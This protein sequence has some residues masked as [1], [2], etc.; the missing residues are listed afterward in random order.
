MGQ[1]P[2]LTP[3]VALQLAI[4]LK[5]SG[6]GRDQA[7]ESVLATDARVAYAYAM[8]VLS[9]V[10]REGEPAILTDPETAFWYAKRFKGRW[11]EAEP[12]IASSPATAYEYAKQVL[13]H[14]WPEAELVIMS[15][16]SSAAGY[17]IHVLNGPWPDAEPI[18][19]QS[20]EWT[21]WYRWL[22]TKDPVGRARFDEV[23]QWASRS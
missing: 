7:L 22:L 4:A 2:K 10:F 6:G 17:A 18:I 14:R 13:G 9:H 15:T 8:S 21:H 12:V 1:R 3:E 20:D 23:R 16:P 11:Q 19:A 5:A